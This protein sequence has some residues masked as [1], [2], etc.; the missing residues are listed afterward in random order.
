MTNL[1]D[2]YRKTAARYDEMHVAAEDEHFIALE[3]TFSLVESLGIQSILDVG[4]GTGR[5]LK[6]YRQRMND[7]KLL[8]IDPSPDLLQKAAQ[9][10]PSAEFSQGTGEQLPFPDESIDLVVATGIM[11]HVDSRNQCIREMFRVARKVV[12]ISDHNNFAFGSTLARRIRL[13]L[14]TFSLLDIVTFIKQGFRRQGYSEDDGW[15]YPYSLLNDFKLISE[16]S[17]QVFILPTRATNS[18]ELTNFLLCQSHVAI[19]ALKLP[20]EQR[21]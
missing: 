1:N 21:S 7:V 13:A 14:F 12:L 6:W 5:S 9:S 10:V 2:Y 11:H 8:G 17:K 20:P 19:L 18:H 15:W 3:R 4:S 16:L